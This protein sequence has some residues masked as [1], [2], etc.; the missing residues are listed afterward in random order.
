MREEAAREALLAMTRCIQHRGPDDGGIFLDPQAGVAL[1]FRRLAIIDLTPLGHQPM[2]SPSGRY[3]LTFNGEI[4]NHHTL[5]RML[6]DA[7]VQFRGRSDTEVLC[8]GFEVWGI[9]ETLSRAAGMFGIA[10][11]DTQ[12]RTLT[13]ARDRIGIKPVHVAQC[14]GVVSYGSELKSIVAAPEFQ[15]AL[16]EEAIREYAALLYVPGPRTVFRNTIKL[17]PGSFLTIRNPA[18]PLPEAE[19][20]W[21]VQETARNGRLTGK[22]LDAQEGQRA[23]ESMLLRVTEEHLESDVPLGAFLSGGIDSSLVVALMTRVSR[24]PVRTFTIAFDSAEHD[25]SAHAEAVAR[26]LGTEHTTIPLRGADALDE[27]KTLVESYDEP[28]ADSSQLPSLLVCRAAR[29]HVTVVLT[30]D[31]GDELFAG[32]NRYR[33]SEQLFPKLDRMPRALRGLGGAALTSLPDAMLQAAYAMARALSGSVPDERL[34]VGKLRKL[35]RLMSSDSDVARYLLLVATERAGGQN[36]PMPEALA[37]AFSAEAPA[38]RLDRMLLA[39]QLSYLPDNQMTKVDRASMA[40]S[41]EAR[42]PLLD[43]RVIELSWRLPAS[44]I[45]EGGQ[46]K[47]PLRKLLYQLVPRE[48]IERPK[49]G[50]SVPLVDW[51]RGPLRPWAEELFRAPSLEG[52]P[53]DTRIVR[54]TWTQFVNGHD[55]YASSVWTSL[56]FESWRAR[57][58]A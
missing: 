41:I 29:R 55:G 2:S 28:F 56:M 21:S 13:L 54:D 9:R 34:V 26:H 27:V 36:T 12:E 45:L 30:G 6:Q 43:H 15:R 20:F 51:L 35:G 25:E 48:L 24:S 19:P 50:F 40:A 39:D 1:G 42:V 31:G 52:S 32:Y 11:W 44:S 57:W 46:S 18:A 3:W 53:L 23:L 8:A 5:R 17:P 4:Y 7:G 38:T 22:V 14:N 47:A 37:A 49:T 33:Y 10:L 58:L 16:D